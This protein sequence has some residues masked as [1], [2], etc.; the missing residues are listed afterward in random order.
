[1]RLARK[2]TPNKNAP[3]GVLKRKADFYLVHVCP[4]SRDG[5]AAKRPGDGFAVG[6]P[7]KHFIV[8]P[9]NLFH[10]V[11]SRP[12]LATDNPGR[13][14][15]VHSAQILL[16]VPLAL[17]TEVPSVFFDFEP[18]HR[19]SFLFLSYNVSVTKGVDIVNPF[20]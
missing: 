8:N 15:S 10:E 20:K 19:L 3:E 18:L 17:T 14:S 2:R 6:F 13:I 5:F 16:V 7:T 4:F 9:L 11:S 12:I 1:V